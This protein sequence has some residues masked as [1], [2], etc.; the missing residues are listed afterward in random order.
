MQIEKQSFSNLALPRRIPYGKY[1]NT[2]LLA[3][4]SIHI[5]FQEAISEPNGMQMPRKRHLHAAGPIRAA[6]G[7]RAQ[8]RK[9]GFSGVGMPTR[10]FLHRLFCTIVFFLYICTTLSE[11]SVWKD[12]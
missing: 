8:Y 11:K 2:T 12:G 6:D 10:N 3:K 7:I 4:A 1:K 9:K 5:S